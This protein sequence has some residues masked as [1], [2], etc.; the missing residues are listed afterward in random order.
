[1][2]KSEI[3]ECTQG[4]DMKNPVFRELLAELDETIEI[5]EV[6][7][8]LDYEEEIRLFKERMSELIQKEVARRGLKKIE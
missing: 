7:P 8:L 3:K 5:W 2:W 6:V 4:G 1:M